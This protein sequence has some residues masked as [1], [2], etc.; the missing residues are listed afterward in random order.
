[1]F[2][3]KLLLTAT[4]WG[5][6]NRGPFQ[7][8]RVSPEQS[9]RLNSILNEFYSS[10]KL[11]ATFASI[12]S[13]KAAGRPLVLVGQRNAFVPVN[14]LIFP[15]ATNGLATVQACSTL[16][17]ALQ[18]YYSFVSF[19]R[20]LSDTPAFDLPDLAS[21]HREFA[22]LENVWLKACGLANLVLHNVYGVE[23][24]DDPARKAILFSIQQL[25]IE[26]K[27]GKSPCVRSNG[28]VFIPGWI[29]ERREDRQSR[30]LRVWIEAEG[31]REPATLQD[32]STGGMGL[33]FCET[34]PVGS[35]II[36]EL[37]DG[38]RLCG[39]VTWASNKRIGARFLQPLMRTD[40]LLVSDNSMPDISAHN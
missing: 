14:P 4:A 40:P 1:M 11:T 13:A 23:R 15:A 10:A 9:V 31:Q 33:A 25:I 12:V 8:G 37:A 6:G 19:A 38:R 3:K 18:S 26:A 39:I 35:Q 7:L 27:N 2:Q 28:T 32:I 24:L 29:E 5:A 30:G 17:D 20:A 34:R 16:I 36:V 21:S 22:Q